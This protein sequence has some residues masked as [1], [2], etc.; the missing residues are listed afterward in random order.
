MR[1]LRSDRRGLAALEFALIAPVLLMI[2]GGVVDL[3]LATVGRSRLANG[4]AQGVQQALAT[5]PG[6]SAASIR[7]F[8]QNGASRSGLTEPVTVTV[9][10]PACYCITGSPAALGAST[11]LSAA[12]ACTGTCSPS[13]SG[14]GAFV[15]ITASYSYQPIMPL[16]ST[17][18]STTVSQTVTA[19]LL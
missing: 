10:G 6:I 11:P 19:R 8:V 17:V 14:P 9:S 3:G 13:A 12:N 18:L 7:I 16:Y 15:V 4:L 5:G 1:A 2:L